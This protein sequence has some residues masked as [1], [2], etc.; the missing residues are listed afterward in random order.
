MKVSP[1]PRWGIRRRQSTCSRG[2]TV[3]A[4]LRAWAA[5]PPS[6]PACVLKG[7]L[8]LV[9]V[10]WS[11]WSAGLIHDLQEAAGLVRHGRASG[12]L[13]S[14]SRPD[15][16]TVSGQETWRGLQEGQMQ[17]TLPLLTASP[18]AKAREAGARLSRASSRMQGLGSRD[19]TSSVRKAGKGIALCAQAVEREGRTQAVCR[20]KALG[21]DLPG[22]RTH[23][24]TCAQSRGGKAP[25]AS[26]ADAEPWLPPR[27]WH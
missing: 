17:A 14:W 19:H 23:G 16:L 25:M 26:S 2:T 3:G 4:T 22:D 20:W 6:V 21:E 12:Q 10:W 1:Q 18:P 5:L 11:H 9:L 15:R 8:G 27:P 7:S 24:E 13:G